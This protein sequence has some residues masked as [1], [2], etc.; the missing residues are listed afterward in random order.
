MSSDAVTTAYNVL[1]L[2][3]TGDDAAFGQAIRAD[4]TSATPTWSTSSFSVGTSVSTPGD[5]PR[6]VTV[7][8]A[9]ADS[10]ALAAQSYTVPTQAVVTL[11][12][13]NGSQCTATAGTL[14]VN[15]YSAS[16]HIASF[17]LSAITCQENSATVSGVVRFKSSDAY[18]SVDTDP[19]TWDFGDQIVGQDGLSKTF[20]F[21]NSGVDT[22]TLGA[23]T[24]TGIRTSYY[25]LGGDNCPATLAPGAACTVTVTSHARYRTAGDGATAYLLLPVRLPGGAHQDRQIP[26]FVQGK[27]A[28]TTYVNAGPEQATVYFGKLPAPYHASFSSYLIDER[29]TGN[30]FTDWQ[31]VSRSA[32]SVTATGLS[33]STTYAYRLRPVI[34]GSATSDWTPNIAARP[35][36]KYGTGMYHRITPFRLVSNHLLRAGSPFTLTV[37]NTR[38]PST[39]I[40]AVVLNVTVAVPTGTTSVYVYPSGTR[41]AAQADLTVNRGDTKSNFVIA[42]VSSTGRFVIATSHGS[43][44]IAVDVS[45]YFSASGLTTRGYGAALHQFTQGGTILDT[46]YTYGKP[47]SGGYFVAAPMNFEP[48]YSKDVTS[49]EVVV[50]AYGSS[51]SGTIA[52]FQT[53]NSIPGTSILS[54]RP[55][56]VT[57]AT[58]IIAAGLWHNATDG[59]YYP[60]VSF[61]NRG[62]RPVQLRVTTLGYFDNATFLYGQRYYPST[63][64][65]LLSNELYTHSRRTLAPGSYATEWTSA[66]NLKITAANPTRSTA[67]SVWPAGYLS[68]Q[69]PVQAQLRAPE[70][71][72]TTAST[73]EATGG[74]NRMYLDNATGSTYVNVWSFGRFDAWPVPATPN[75]V[76]GSPATAAALPAVASRAPLGQPAPMLAFVH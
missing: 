11:V 3:G 54:Y 43:A 34:S 72:T 32:G 51:G 27:S 14:R 47:L 15:N 12:R 8:I 55:G 76:G 29:T 69:H 45:G 20:T 44:K 71:H 73:I 65:H 50:T 13:E 56:Q 5:S 31:T 70:H 39:H 19:R 68:I 21:T 6:Q 28:A 75:S 18:E 4:L 59:H 74:T 10:S 48:A 2:S 67:I 52:G 46:R 41:H 22:V 24:L 7:Q 60:S 62:S 49:L 61:Y 66:M 33:S 63:P 53:G 40:S 42:R 36:P 17:D 64:V 23:P 58:A 25:V 9:T 1:T 26:L 38:V 30:N 16:S 37:A 35:W 57:T